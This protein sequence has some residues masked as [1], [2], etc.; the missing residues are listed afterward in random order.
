[1]KRLIIVL[2]LLITSRAFSLGIPL[3]DQAQISVITLG[4]DQNDLIQA[5][6]HS[7]VR[8][9]DPSQGIDEV[10]NYGVFSFNQPNF[11]LNFARGH[12]LYLLGISSYPEFRDVYIYYHRFVHEQVLNLTQQQK[13]KIFDYL[14]WNA[15]QENRG[16]LYDYFFSNCATKVRDL[17]TTVL[18]D[19]ISFDSTYIKTN[20]TIRELMNSYLGPLPWGRLGLNIGLGSPI[21]RV[22]LPHEYMYLP[23]YIE[24]SFDHASL[25]QNGNV[26]PLV[27]TKII[28]FGPQPDPPEKSTVHPWLAFGLLLVL[29]IFLSW[30]DWQRKKIS[31]WFD[32]T[33]FLIVGLI[34]TVLL[35]LWTATDHKACVGNYN[36]IWALPTHLIVAVMLILRNKPAWL[37]DYFFAT[38]GIDLLLLITWPILPQGLDHFLIPLVITL[39]I[40][41]IALFRLLPAAK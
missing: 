32:I 30:R 29:G 41:S 2:L 27:K 23:D 11:Y 16:Y 24:S 10:Y 12:N 15:R 3:S 9:L 34:G 20:Y 37:K 22:A 21:D 38:A 6:G 14:Q 31:V 26:V 17:L 18:H 28:V 36:L 4:P 35:L 5:F 25:K 33:L 19:E 13:Q 7:A 39:L 8:V 40:R 1:M